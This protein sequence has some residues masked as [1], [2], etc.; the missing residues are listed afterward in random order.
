MLIRC[1]G[2][3]ANALM[4]RYGPALLVAGLGYVL[5]AELID[6]WSRFVTAAGAS[7]VDGR[8]A[9]RASDTAGDVARSNPPLPECAECRVP[10][11][12]HWAGGACPV[13]GALGGPVH[14]AYGEHADPGSPTAAVLARDALAAA[15]NLPPMR[16]DV[17]A[18]RAIPCPWCKAPPGIGCS[19]PATGHP[20][21]VTAVH[22][23]RFAAA[24]YGDCPPVDGERLKA[25]KSPP[26]PLA[27]LPKVADPEESDDAPE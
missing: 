15:L 23:A 9:P 1:D 14:R 12:R 27:G 21:T 22:P 16:D 4:G 10:F 17:G 24:G 13:C 20:L 18:A 25:A 19:V 8:A 5:P 11:P 7:I 3:S 2:N 6:Q 26:D